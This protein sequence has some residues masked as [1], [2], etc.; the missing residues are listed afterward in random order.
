MGGDDVLLGGLGNDV[1][2][3]GAGSDTASYDSATAGVAVNLALVGQQNTGGGGLDTLID[4]ENLLGSHSND[5]LTGN[6]GNNVLAG[7][8]GNDQLT[9]GAGADTFKWL[10]GETGTTDITD[11]TLGQDKLDLS[12]LLTGEHSNAGSLDDFLTM[13]FGTNTT[14]TVDTNTAANPGGTGQTIVLEGVNLQAAYGAA[15]T[16]SVITHMLDDGSLKADA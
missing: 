15:D 3:G 16:A 4:M 9:G 8:G 1:L 12:Q 10:A 11:F 13:A 14:I 5:V 7:N 2:D 6:S